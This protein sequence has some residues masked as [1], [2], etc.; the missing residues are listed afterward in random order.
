MGKEQFFTM[1]RDEVRSWAYKY[2]IPFRGA[3]KEQEV[4]EILAKIGVEWE[5][6]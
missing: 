6:D 5:V 2:R 4:R 1:S 3:R